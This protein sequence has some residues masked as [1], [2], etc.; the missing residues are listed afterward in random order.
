MKKKTILFLAGIIA[1]SAYGCGTKKQTGSNQ[2]ELTCWMPLSSVAASSVS[3]YAETPFAKKLEEAIGV[4]INYQHPP[5]GQETEKFN[6]LMAMNQLPDVII[7]D[8]PDYPGGPGKAIS[9][10]KIIDLTDDIKTKAPDFYK[11]VSEN[12]EWARLMKTADGKIYSFP[13]I[14]GDKSLL[15]SQGLVLRKDWLDEL[16]L[17]IPET[18]DDWEKTL[19]AF[20]E[21]KGAT[22]LSVAA[23]HFNSGIFCGAYGVNKNFYIEDGKVKYGQLEHGFKDFL[24]KMNDWYNKGLLDKDIA[25]YDNKMIDSKILSGKLGATVGSIGSGIGKWMSMAES[26]TYNLAAAPIPVLNKG[27]EIKFGFG[28]LPVVKRGGAISTSCKNVDAA[29]KMLNYGYSD[30][31]HMLYNFGIEGESYE[32][33]D[34][35][36][37]YTETITNNSEGLSMTV[38]LARYAQSPSMGTFVQ[39]KRYME[40]YAALPQQQDA[41]KLWGSADTTGRLM[42]YLYYDE[43]KLSDTVKKETAIGTYSDEMFLKFIIGIEPISKYDDFVAELK[44][45]GIDDVLA[46]K[47]EAYEKYKNR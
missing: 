39:D 18:I 31:G 15:I 33:K 45:R 37:T 25:S 26:D 43:S 11:V 32:M 2:A 1:V 44:N 30:E 42:P 41:L 35:Y 17:P 20:K 3:N 29:Y 9:E 14:R 19:T 22:P 46:T 8:W 27:D 10:N 34:G 16:G 38:A 28:D 7:A 36:P 47:Q 4:K 24:I 6:I 23:W 13:F 40:Q 12:E 5:Q 21:K